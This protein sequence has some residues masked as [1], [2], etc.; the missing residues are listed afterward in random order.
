MVHLPDNRLSLPQVT[1]CAVTSVNVRATV[2]ALQTCLQQI[3]FAECLLFSDAALTSLHPE[4]KVVPIKPLLTSAAYSD[5]LLRQLADHVSTTHCL[6]A[7]W[8]G[9]VLDARRW[10]PAFLDYD[11]IG[12][13]W[14]HFNDGQN[15]GNGGFSLRSRRLMELCRSNGFQQIHPEDIAI[16]R[17]NRLW[18]Q[19]QGMRFASKHLA[20]TFSV[21]RTGDI[22][23]AFGYHGAFNM[24][25]ALGPDKFWDIYCDL[26]SRG[27]IMHDFASIV[28][29]MWCGQDAL[30][31]SAKMIRDYLLYQC[32]KKR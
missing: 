3:D 2:Q 28:K 31:R 7:Q 30:K 22:N 25:R 19:S 29:E 13:S 16:G 21:E 9:H 5:F 6:V 26:D 1:L 18:L 10:K 15:V 32:L 14:P 8:D 27:T 11:Y 4:I 24:P 17:T 20:D 12:A 23:K